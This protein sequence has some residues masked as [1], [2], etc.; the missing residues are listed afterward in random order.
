MCPLFCVLSDKG[1]ILVRKHACTVCNEFRM[2]YHDSSYWSYFLPINIL[3]LQAKLC[4]EGR[5]ALYSYCEEN[6]VSFRKV[7][8]LIVATQANQVPILENLMRAG[9]ANGVTD[10]RLMEATEAKE[11]EPH[12]QCVK[13]LWSPSS[14]ILDT[15]SFMLTLQVCSSQCVIYVFTCLTCFSWN[16]YADFP[17]VR[18]NQE[19][20]VNGKP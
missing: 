10:L 19:E 16:T 14:G 11:L 18:I 1:R 4:V 13:A 9:E 17:N 15:H 12:V 3:V 8:K 6:G 2:I 5:Q 20:M 7:G